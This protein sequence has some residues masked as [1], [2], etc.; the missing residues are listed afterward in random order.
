MRFAKSLIRRRCFTL[1][2]LLVVV[3]IIAVL[4]AMLLPVLGK[5]RYRTQIVQCT[6]GLRQM[7]LGVISYAGDNDEFYPH[8]SIN[9][10]YLS[11]E[12]AALRIVSGGETCD[13]RPMFRSYIADLNGAFNCP[14]SPLAAGMDLRTSTSNTVYINYDL[15]FGSDFDPSRLNQAVYKDARMVRVGDR[16][17]IG[18]KV[19]N[20]LAADEDEQWNVSGYAARRMA[21]RDNPATATYSTANTASFVLSWYATSNTY[22]RNPM[23][24]NFLFDDGSVQLVAR[25]KWNDSR[26]LAIPLL[27]TNPTYNAQAFLVQ[28]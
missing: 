2:E 1:I 8:R 19:Y 17:K 21:H 22:L 23:D 18:G 16:A 5:A 10:H 11:A 6:N 3:A 15:F 7:G 12:Y 25:L 24:R 14:L 27:A 9:R 13:D 26:Q 20:V 28:Q 4:A